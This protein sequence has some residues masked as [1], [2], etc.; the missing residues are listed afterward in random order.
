MQLKK[1]LL[2]LVVTIILVL[3][4]W[5]V[6]NLQLFGDEAFYWLEGQHLALSY[7]ELPAWTA[8][9]TR[10]GTQVFGTHYFAVRTLAFLGY[11]SL[12][13]C[14][15]LL[16][17]KE[18]YLKSWLILLS[19]PLFMLIATMALPDIW[20][21]VSV[22]WFSY[23]LKKALQTSKASHWLMLGILSAISL[24]VHVRMWIWLFFACSAFLLCFRDRKK[25]KVILLYT[26]PIALLGLI[27]ILWFNYNHDFVLFTFQ[28]GRR[29]PWTFQWSNISFL[30]AQ[31]IVTTP[32]VLF[33]WFR[34]L[35]RFKNSTTFKQWILLTAFLHWLFYVFMSLFAD[36]LRTT[37]H[38]LI[39]S[40]VP[41]LTIV[42]ISLQRYKTLTNWAIITGNM[43]T[44][45]LLFFLINNTEEHSNLQARLLDNSLG[46]Q[47]LAKEVTKQQAKTNSHTIITDYFMTAAELAFEL[48]EKSTILVL[49]HNKNRKHGRQK[50][51]EIMHM[52]LLEPQNFKQPALLVVED[53][54]LKL[55]DKG[56]YYTQ[57]CQNFRQF[58]FQSN[59][60]IENTTKKF[61]LFHVNNQQD[62]PKICEIPPLFYLQHTFK[63]DTLK[64]TGWVIQHKFGITSLKV[65]INGKS[66]AIRNNKI[67]NTGIAQQF[68]EIDDPNRPHNAFSIQIKN[69][70]QAPKNFY[71][72]APNSQAL[73]FSSQYYYLF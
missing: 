7:S 61:T 51:L 14:L 10:L 3:Q 21:V 34:T 13:Y 68:P 40:Y 64:L 53:S 16:N 15:Y 44:L 20:L 69:P 33:L 24:N 22:M 12:F 63:N 28:F 5:L 35:G 43:F 45:G 62:K 57:L 70:N 30:I 46:W 25:L 60:S 58:T 65:I 55:Q 42:S 67:K 47:Q 73:P 36:G 4:V 54:T 49:T 52:A 27:P 38:W 8:W 50:Q 32:I 66:Y 6:F 56:H 39:I 17:D 72:Q 1:P 29:H 9:M 18:N 48:K 71:L 37:V 11:L 59:L 26:L 31:I 19:L 2:V 23:F 41:V